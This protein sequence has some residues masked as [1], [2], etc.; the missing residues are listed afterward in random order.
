MYKQFLNLGRQPLANKFLT[1]AQTLKK[2]VFYDL[3]IGFNSEYSLVSILK[4]IPSKKMFNDKYPYRSSM[5]NTIIKY[6]YNLSKKI[7]KDFN[8]NCF[9]EIGSNDGTLMKNF[10]KKKSICVEPCKNHAKI[11]T[12]MGYKTYQNFWNLKLAKK[13]KKKYKTVDLIYSANAIS[14]INDLKS[15]FKAIRYLLSEKGVLI[16]EDPSLLNCLK[17]GSYDQFYNE[18]IYV[19][20]LLSMVK[21]LKKHDME[22]YNVEQLSTHGGS[23]RYYIKKESNNKFKIQKSINNQLLKETKYGLDKFKTYKIFGKKVENSKKELKKIFVNL[24]KQ[25]KKIVSYGATAKSCTVF[26]YC[27]IGNDLIDCVLDTTP[28]KVGKYTPGTHIKIKKYNKNSL[29]NID[30]A[31]LSAWNFKNEIFMKEKKYIKNGLKFITHT[32]NPQ[33]IKK[34]NV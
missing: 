20:S 9:L 10:D 6:F 26:N 2:E 15:V 33:I 21:L 1:K 25:N 32:P 5:S 4:T 17:L 27:K 28:D 24:K 30:F 13:I 18:H 8:P 23:L 16:I 11:T 22:V 29:K 14:H 31:F 34:I 3:N 19:F 7:I 12:R